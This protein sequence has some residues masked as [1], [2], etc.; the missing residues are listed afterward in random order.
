MFLHFLRRGSGS[1]LLLLLARILLVTDKSILLFGI[2]LALPLVWI[3]IHGP[4]SSKHVNRYQPVMRKLVPAVHTR[5]LSS[6]FMLQARA[7]PGPIGTLLELA[8][9]PMASEMV[10]PNLNRR[11]I[12]GGSLV[13]NTEQRHRRRS[14]GSQRRTPDLGPCRLQ[15]LFAHLGM[16]EIQLRNQAA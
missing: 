14:L 12:A 3:A 10:L 2:A 13:S 16:Q 5:R 11:L 15:P 6:P 7:V 1:P 9:S 8:S 4:W